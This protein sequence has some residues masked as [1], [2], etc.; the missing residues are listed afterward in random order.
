MK[1]IE[2]LKF[3]IKL[4]RN[5]QLKLEIGMEFNREILMIT[6][7]NLLT[8]MHVLI[9]FLFKMRIEQLTI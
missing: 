6:F 2:K 3:K 8:R 4:E 7:L 1:F 5:I 9:I